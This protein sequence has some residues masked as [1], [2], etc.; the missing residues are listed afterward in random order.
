[1]YILFSFLLNP[2]LFQVA[3]DNGDFRV[4][5]LTS[6]RLVNFRLASNNLDLLEDGGDSDITRH[7]KS[8]KW[9]TTSK[10]PLPR[11]EQ[12]NLIQGVAAAGKVTKESFTP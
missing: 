8:S 3:P 9:E 5:A 1:M 7:L 6:D 10:L 12:P 4:I 2:Q 11:L